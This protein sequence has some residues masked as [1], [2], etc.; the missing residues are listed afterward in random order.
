MIIPEIL[1]Q[2]GFYG[3]CLYVAVFNWF[4]HKYWSLIWKGICGGNGIPQPNELVKFFATYIYVFDSGLYMLLDKPVDIAFMAMTL[5]TIGVTAVSSNPFK[6]KAD[7][8]P[9]TQK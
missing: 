3:F 8:T 6:K 1:T 7:G 2:A 5:G 4:L 9:T